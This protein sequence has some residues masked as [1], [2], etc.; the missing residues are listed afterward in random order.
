M[1]VD[2]PAA[3]KKSPITDSSEESESDLF[4][5]PKAKKK[6]VVDSESEESEEISDVEKDEVDEKPKVSLKIFYVLLTCEGLFP[7]ISRY[8]K[9]LQNSSKL[10]RLYT[11]IK[12]FF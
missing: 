2:K 1:E 7:N 4:G 12:A 5:E 3:K 9:S 8:Y 10:I 11:K 6:H